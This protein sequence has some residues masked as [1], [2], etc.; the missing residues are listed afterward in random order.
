MYF[1]VQDNT[2]QL[3]YQLMAGSIVPRPI[4][5]ISTRSAEGMDNLAPYSFFTVA[6]CNPPVL[7]VTQVN[8]RDRA[9]KDTLNNLSAAGQCVV[10]I[11]SHDQAAL[12]NASC[13]DYP[14]TISEFDA[15]GI[16][17]TASALVEPCGVAAA[18]VRFECR[19]R[20]IKLISAEPMGGT[21][22]LLDV[23]GIHVDDALLDNG[24]IN[25]AL[26]DAIGKLGGDGYSTTRDR[27][28][29]SRP[30]YSAG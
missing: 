2:A 4:A 8:P 5:W 13:A 30:V 24:Q 12:M 28:A 11:V 9:A 22:M 16:A 20:E 23:L 21:M 10:N 7:A 19:L 1:S 15:L 29:M 14:P 26:L 17:R 18:Q 27:F 25:P 3:C 6:S